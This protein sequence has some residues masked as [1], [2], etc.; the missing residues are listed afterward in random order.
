MIAAP[1]AMSNGLG[2]TAGAAAAGALGGM[3]A[4]SA[5][6]VESISAAVVESTSFFI[7]C[8]LSWPMPSGNGTRTSKLTT[9]LDSPRYCS[10]KVKAAAVA[11]FLGGTRVR[12]FECREVLQSGH[13][14]GSEK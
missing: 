2:A 13:K 6:V 10:G 3:S 7:T 12:Q 9:E 8:P 4:A 11:A 14:N 1:N 5:R